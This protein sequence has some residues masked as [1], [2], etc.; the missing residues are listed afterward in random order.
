MSPDPAK[1]G[2]PPVPTR[3]ALRVQLST[4]AFPSAAATKQNR[5][6]KYHGDRLFRFLQYQ[7][8]PDERALNGTYC[9][10]QGTCFLVP[11]GLIRLGNDLQLKTDASA[12][13]QPL[14]SLALKVLRWWKDQM[15]AATRFLFPSPR[16]SD[17]PISSVKTSWTNTLKRAGVPYFPIYQLRHAF[18]TRMGKVAADAVLTQ[19]MTVITFLAQSPKKPIQSLR[20]KAYK[21]LKL[22]M[23]SWWTWGGS[24]SRPPGCKPGALPTELQAQ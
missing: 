14:S 17:R 6:Q 1:D 3:S 7:P 23:K 19:A 4:L 5:P 20:K 13:P 8:T 22:K 24:N 9:C 21:W 16:F 11:A 18:C 2:I 10:W 15:P 12:R